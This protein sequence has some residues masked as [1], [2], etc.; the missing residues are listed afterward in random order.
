M[1][2]RAAVQDAVASALSIGRVTKRERS[3]GIPQSHKRAVSFDS[4]ACGF[5]YHLCATECE[6]WSVIWPSF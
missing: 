2:E 6:C 3:S 5:M 4:T 1:H